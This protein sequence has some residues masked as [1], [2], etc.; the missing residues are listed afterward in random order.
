MERAALETLDRVLTFT[1]IGFDI[2]GQL[3]QI[4][5]SLNAQGRTEQ[6]RNVIPSYGML[7]ITYRLSKQPKQR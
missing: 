5:Y 6:W 7:R 3:S 4:S 1:L 2:L